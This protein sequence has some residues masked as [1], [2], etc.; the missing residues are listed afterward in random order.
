MNIRRLF[1]YI[2]FPLS[3]AAVSADDGLLSGT[4]IGSVSV[5]YATGDSSRTVNTPANAFDGDLSTIYASYERSYTWVG[6]DLGKQY[7]ITAIGFASRAGWPQRLTLGIFEGGNNPDFSDAV[8]LYM[9]K[10][11]P[12]SNVLT[13]VAVNVSRG[14]RYVR[15]V[16]PNN[17]RCNIAEVQFYGHE[18]EGDDSQFYTPTNLPLL[19]IHTDSAKEITSK[20]IYRRAIISVIDGGG[21][22]IY[23]DSLDIRGRGNASWGFPKKPYKLK[24]DHK[25]HLLGMP[26][27]A[28]KWTLI[29]NYGDK[30]LI[31]NAIA[32]KISE[33]MGMT[34]TPALRMTDVM[35]NGEYKGTYQACDQ[36]EVHKKR[37]NITEMTPADTTAETLSGGYLVEIDAYAGQEPSKFYT[38]YYNLP[39]T[40]KSP[41]A[42][43]IAPKQSARISRDFS[44][45]AGVVAAS[46]YNSASYGFRRYLDEDSFLRHFLVGEVSANT[47]TYWS[48]YMYRD[49]DSLRFHTGPVWDFDLGFE[50][51]S[52]THPVGNISTYMCLS[53]QSSCAGDMRTFVS[54]IISVDRERLKQLWS[55]AR[56]DHGLSYEN[57]ELFIDSLTSYIDES[58]KLNFMRWPILS[59][60]V[61]QNFQALGSYDAE[62]QTVLD[63]LKWRIPWLDNKVGLI[64]A[65]IQGVK[66]GTVT[67]SAAGDGIDVNGLTTTARIDIYTPDG[68]VAGS[69][70][71]VSGDRHITLPEGIYIVRVTSGGRTYRTKVKTGAGSGF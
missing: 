37:V 10:E 13:K 49:R 19:T 50:N 14:F 18:G 33:C 11:Q 40:I 57:L 38:S 48:V 47:D 32:F 7:V 56:N 53:P 42:D 52:R 63:Y 58:Q 3:I 8:P 55:E 9:I 45:M 16:G 27:K 71:G 30:T 59:T 51:D 1:L 15:Y 66:A 12:E 21:S 17:V 6:L 43:D 20:E 67:V 41:D 54:R 36:I 68:A 31:R 4:P 60:P 69:L 44:R 70:S 29:N 64:A 65:G 26:A 22:S 35:L 39:V 34:Y 46:Y 2:L 62:V 24:L 28:K 61:H 25:T 23:T 5:N